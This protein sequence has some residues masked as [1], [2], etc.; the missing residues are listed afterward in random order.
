MFLKDGR[1]DIEETAREARAAVTIELSE[2]ER[3]RD[4]T[5]ELMIAKGEGIDRYSGKNVL[6]YWRDAFAG[7][8]AG[9]VGVELRGTRPEKVAVRGA[10]AGFTLLPRRPATAL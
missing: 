2:F 10:C 9:D 7:A 1:L 5:R 4:A 8:R 6:P 3:E